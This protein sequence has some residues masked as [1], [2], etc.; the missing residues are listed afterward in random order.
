MQKYIPNPL[1]LNKHKFDLRLFCLV[2]SFQPLE[3]FLHQEGFVGEINNTFCSSAAHLAHELS[4]AALHTAVPTGERHPEAAVRAPHQLL[5]P[6]EQPQQLDLRRRARMLWRKQNQPR[7]RLSKVL[8]ITG[9][10][11]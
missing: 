11:C 1:L 9:T 4:G 3:A 2:T 8:V 6:E 10:S 5:D 7:V